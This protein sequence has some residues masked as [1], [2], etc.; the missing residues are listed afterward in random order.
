MDFGAGL[1]AEAEIELLE[2]SIPRRLLFLAEFHLIAFLSR[3]EI[4]QRIL[5]TDHWYWMNR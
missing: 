2:V 3:A 5:G 1:G 4:T